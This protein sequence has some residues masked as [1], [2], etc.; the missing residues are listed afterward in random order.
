MA[1]RQPVYRRDDEEAP[2][3]RDVSRL[4]VWGFL[5]AALLGLA[6][7]AVWVA[8]NLIRVHVLA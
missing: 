8:W 2:A 7:G 1:R 4:L 5:I 6:T 3:S